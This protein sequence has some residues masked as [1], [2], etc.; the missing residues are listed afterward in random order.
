[1]TILLWNSAKHTFLISNYEIYTDWSFVSEG[2]VI[3]FLCIWS[4]YL[5]GLVVTLFGIHISQRDQ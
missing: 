1:M 4:D 5:V 2:T 3:F